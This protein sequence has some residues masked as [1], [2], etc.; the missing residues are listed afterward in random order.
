MEGDGGQSAQWRDQTK[1]LEKSHQLQNRPVLF[2]GLEIAALVLLAGLINSKETP[3]YLDA[4][5][6][7]TISTNGLVPVVFTLTCIARY[8]EISS[9]LLMLSWLTLLL[10]TATLACIPFFWN[11]AVRNPTTSVD[12]LRQAV[13]NQRACGINWNLNDAAA[14]CGFKTFGNIDVHTGNTRN[15]WIWVMWAN[16]VIWAVFSTIR[17]RF[18]RL[19]YRLTG[20]RIVSPAIMFVVHLLRISNLLIQSILQPITHLDALVF[21]SDS[22]N[23]DLCTHAS[24]ANLYRVTILEKDSG[25]ISTSGNVS[26]T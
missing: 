17:Q 24:R 8:H 10:A 19:W 2:C 21:R 3:D 5:S 6:L 25:R 22:R 14:L 4:E 26:N 16:C 20:L 11:S 15:G 23:L 7:V 12:N 13:D 9:Y 18:R 1:P